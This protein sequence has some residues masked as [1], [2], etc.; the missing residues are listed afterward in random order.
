VLKKHYKTKH[1]V[2]W[3]GD[4]STLFRRVKVQTFFRAGGLQRYFVVRGQEEPRSRD[5]ENLDALLAE[6]KVTLVKHEKE[7]QVMGR[8]VERTDRTGWFNRTG[9][10]EHFKERNLAHIARS[11]RLPGK[12]EVKLKRAARVVELLIEQSVAGLASLE[13]ETRRG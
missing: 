8:E 2:L 10:P 1:G 4:T 6:W 12:E 11:I 13:H 3:I 5:R 9:W 7:M